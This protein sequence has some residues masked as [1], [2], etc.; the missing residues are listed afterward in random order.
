MNKQDLVEILEAFGY[1]C[2]MEE[3]ERITDQRPFNNNG[4]CICFSRVSTLQ[5]DLK[6]QTNMLYQEAYRNGYDDD[7]IVLIEYSESAIK[8]D[9]EERIGLRKLKET[10]N[11]EKID[12]VIIYEI[13]RLSRRS[14]VLYSI[15]D[16]LIDHNVNLICIKPYMRLLDP[17]GKMSQTAS[18]LFSL[19]STLSESE[20]MIKKERFMRAKNELRRQGK[21]SAGS[22]IFGYERQ[23]EEL[24][25]PPN[26]L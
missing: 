16:F 19:F 2:N 21:K 25:P 17:D 24:H 10:I 12:C 11:N 9:E 15:R 3:L 14:T 8:L 7:H 5:Q 20:M 22:V 18:I 4:K 23:R 13:S 26:R 6:Q 1:E